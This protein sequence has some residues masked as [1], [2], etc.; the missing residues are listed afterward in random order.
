M[1]DTCERS[2]GYRISQC[3]LPSTNAKGRTKIS[4]PASSLTCR[5]QSRQSSRLV[6]A[7][8]DRT[9]LAAASQASIRS[10]TDMPRRSSRTPRALEQW[11]YTWVTYASSQCAI[12][13][14]RPC[15]LES[16]EDIKGL[17]RDQAHM[18]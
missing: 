6:D 11:K 7:M 13:Q 16:Y 12:E 1:R 9:L 5:A 17:V 2:R 10:D 14:D 18:A 15:T 4:S 8:S 3:G